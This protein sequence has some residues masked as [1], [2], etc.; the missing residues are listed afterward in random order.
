MFKTEAIDLDSS[1]FSLAT[2]ILLAFILI[3]CAFI[4]VW[5]IIDFLAL[6]K[7]EVENVIKA[8]ASNFLILSSVLPIY[9]AIAMPDGLEKN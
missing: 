6:A 3:I 1:L 7:L 2:M 4:G 8:T 9:K 5:Q